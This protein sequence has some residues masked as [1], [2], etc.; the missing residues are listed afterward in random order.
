MPTRQLLRAGKLTAF[1]EDGILRDIRLGPYPV[2]HSIYAAV[3]D[4]NWSTIVPRFSTYSVKQHADSFDVHF[5]A[6]HVNDEVDF[7]WQGTISG[8]SESIISFAFDGRARRTFLKNRVGFC[9]LHPMELAGSPVEIETPTGTLVSSFPQHISPH[10]PFKDIVAMRYTLAALPDNPLELRFEGDI[11]E[12]E[13]Q[14]NWTDASYK[15][16]CTPLSRPY[17]VEIHK[18]DLIR[19]VVV[20]QVSGNPGALSATTEQST[21]LAVQVSVQTIGHLPPLGLELADEHEALSVTDIERL[22]MLQ[23]AHLWVELDLDIEGWQERLRRA[24]ELAT[25]LIAALELSIIGDRQ[26]GLDELATV[27][28]ALP[29][30]VTRV[31]LFAHGN[32]VTTTEVVERARE[33]FKRAKISPLIGG[34]SRANFAEFNRASL[35][36]HTIDVAGYPINPQV[37]AFDDASLVETLRAQAA[38]VTNA[39]RLAPTKPLS[40]GPVTLK[41]RFNPVAV[42]SPAMVRPGE[43]LDNVDTRQVSLFAAGWTIGSV[44]Q[45]ASAGANWLTYYQT[46]GWRGLMERTVPTHSGSPLPVLPGALF[47]LYHIFAD[48]GEF[49]SAELLALETSDP[50]LIEAL[51]LRREG[52]LLVL[53][54]SL[55]DQERSIALTIPPLQNATLRLLDETTAQQA[56]DDGESYRWQSRQELIGTQRQLTLHLLPYAIARL[57]G[58]LQEE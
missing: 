6:E 13:D 31:F 10:Q 33:I 40:I 34:G 29:A 23:L 4:R 5:S 30:P 22:H 55:S 8:T 54:A 35:P 16:Y 11:F 20:L 41:P 53:V 28:S 50:T 14:R 52:R 7:A 58:L 18:G 19:Q 38:T 42:G 26:E 45:L 2:L 9:V 39:R 51:A 43:L 17:P 36:L 44:R 25:K 37:H 3:R 32:H 24:G 27:I 48:L 46:H 47:P 21:P 56:F 49:A 1:L 15:T 57:D 12:S